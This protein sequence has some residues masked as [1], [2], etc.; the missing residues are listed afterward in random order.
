MMITNFNSNLR[1]Q[2]LKMKRIKR[3][4]IFLMTIPNYGQSS[5]RL[6]IY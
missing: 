1:R 4:E 6:T 3:L 2:K 5:L